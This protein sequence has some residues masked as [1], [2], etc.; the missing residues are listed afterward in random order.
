MKDQ[1][2]NHT[3]I[4]LLSLLASATVS[5]APGASP[6][7]GLIEI[8]TT[9]QLFIDDYIIQSLSHAKRVLNPAVKHPDNPI[10]E[11]DRPWEGHYVGLNQIIYD[12]D[13]GLFRM[14]YRTTSK[15]A[16]K[17]GGDRL[18]PYRFDW[19]WEDGRAVRQKVEEIYGYSEYAE[20]KD[21]KLCYA[22][23][24]D[25]IHW[26]KPNLGKVEFNGS[27][28]NNILPADTLTPLFWDR[29]ETDPAKR[30]KT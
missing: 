1:T 6:S 2:R 29:H 4:V 28:N 21:W 27:K 13:K 18:R 10:L 23:S 14:W 7:S 26:E 30:Y 8:G 19:R 9:K 17:K 3:T 11:A 22:T 16:S 15:F 12:E 24:R 5:P 25:G 20:S